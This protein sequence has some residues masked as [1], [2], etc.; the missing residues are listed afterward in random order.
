ML[1]S[2]PSS[3]FCAAIL[4]AT[5]LTAS[6]H[7]SQTTFKRD[8][9]RWVATEQGSLSVDAGGQLRIKAAGNIRVRGANGSQITYKVTRTIRA[10][11][12]REAQAMI[13][14]FPITSARQGATAI[15]QVAYGPFATNLEIFVPRGLESTA[16]ETLGGDID[17]SDLNGGLLAEASG[18][19]INVGHV[20]GNIDA[21]AA[22]GMIVLGVIGGNAHCLSGGGTI[23]ATEIRGDALLETGGGDIRLRK[24]GGAVRASTAGG[25]IEVVEAKGTVQAHTFGGPIQIGSAKGVHCESASGSIEAQ[26]LPGI[27][28]LDSFLSTGSG[29]ITLW[30]PSNIRV[31]I[32]A[33]NEGSGNVGTVISDF[34]GLH[35]KPAGAAVMADLLINGGGPIVQL[36]GN[37][38]RIYIRKR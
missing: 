22:G 21:R 19:R 5:F 9:G 4:A 29:D 17:V 27:A 37:G 33:Q 28:V 13:D 16:I 34:P 14:H 6:Q 2:V 30:I 15:L 18:G 11:R 7:S 20:G 1:R 36:A 12:E 3:S 35:V 26:F 38:G 31:S 32:R 23:N 10:V 25:R 8:G 24:A